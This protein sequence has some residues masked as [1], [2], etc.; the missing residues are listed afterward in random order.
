[1]QWSDYSSPEE[2]AAAKLFLDLKQQSLAHDVLDPRLDAP[3]T[4][5]WFE[6]D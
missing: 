3:W 1:M 4:Y 2:V 5:R 6:R